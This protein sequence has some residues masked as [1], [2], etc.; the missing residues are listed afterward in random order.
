MSKRDYLE[1]GSLSASE[2]MAV[3]D[4]AAVLAAA[5]EQRASQPI[6]AGLRA[7]LITDDSGF[8]NL[9]AFELGI[10]ELGGSVT[11]VPV[12]LNGGEAPADLGAYLSNWFDLLVVRT[13]SHEH[14]VAFANGATVPVVNART[15][16]NHPCE[17]LGDLAFLAHRRGSI[18]GLVVAFVGAADNILRSWD[19]AARVLPIRVI[20]VCPEGYEHDAGAVQVVRTLLEAGPVDVVECDCWPEATGGRTADHIRAAFTPH[21]ITAAV[22]DRLPGN[23]LFIPCPPVTRGQEVDESAMRSSRCVVV[24]AKAWLLHAQN[25]LLHQMR[26]R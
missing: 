22:L 23:P 8:R 14:L 12:S 20:Q 15:R 9:S 3:L 18:D 24:G 6:L 25:A 17:V 5:F 1:F 26:S 16:Q 11:H 21:Q 10:R 19:E 7:A 4:H 13:R 2:T